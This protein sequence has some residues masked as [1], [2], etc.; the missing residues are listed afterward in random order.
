VHP[1]CDGEIVQRSTKKG[2][3]FWGCSNYPHCTFLSWFIP[4]QGHCPY[5]GA[6]YLLEKKQK[7]GKILT[8][9]SNKEC[10]K[11]IDMITSN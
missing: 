9:C 2:K 10:N 3:T 1:H 11:E 4:V 8:V 6:T 5:C 7:G